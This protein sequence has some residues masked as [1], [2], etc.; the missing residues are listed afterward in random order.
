MDDEVVLLAHVILHPYN[1]QLASR[2]A[3]LLLVEFASMSDGLA[4]K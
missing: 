4:A 1:D 3:L 2:T